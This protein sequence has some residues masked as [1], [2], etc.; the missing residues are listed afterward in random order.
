MKRTGAGEEFKRLAEIGRAITNSL[1]FSEVLELIV[2]NT[3][4]LVEADA[5][6]LLMADDD[7]LLR[8]R[9][10][11]GLDLED[12]QDFAAPFDE[13]VIDKLQSAICAEPASVIVSVPVFS[14]NSLNGLLV[15]KRNRELSEEGKRLLSAFADQASIA[16]RNAQLYEYETETA[17][18]QRI[19]SLAALRESEERFRQLA[20]NINDVFWIIGLPERNVLYVSPA[21][22]KRWGKSRAEL[23]QD[24]RAWQQMIHPDDQER[25]ERSFVE[26]AQVGKF[27]VEYR[28]ILP[29]KSVHWIRDR[30]Y[31]IKTDGGK[32]NRIA[33][34]AEDITARK[35]AEA[36][37]EQLLARERAARAEAER[38]NHLKDEFLATVSH[39]L[40]TPLTAILG[41]SDM[42]ANK[43]IDS[44]TTARALETILRNARAQQQI[45]DDILDVSR[46]ITGKLHLE[47]REI[48][49]RAS[50]EAAV[51]AVR[52][53][54][55]GKG[56]QLETDF[57]DS[58]ETVKCDPDR[59]QQVV[60]NLLTNA[61]KFTPAGGRIKISLTHEAAAFMKITVSD[62]GIGI[63]QNFLPYVF[64]RFRQA[65]GTSTRKHGGLGLGLSLVRHL[66]EMHGGTV[67]AESK[68]EGQGSTFTLLLPLVSAKVQSA[69]EKHS[70]KNDAADSLPKLLK[71]VKVLVVD[72]D[73]DSLEL[74]SF[75]L[76]EYGAQIRAVDSTAKALTAVTEFTPDVLLSDIAMPETNGYDLIRRVRDLSVK[77]SQG[78]DLYAI[79]LTA[80]TRED[81]R[82]LALEAGFQAH[83]SKPVELADLAQM[84]AQINTKK[85]IT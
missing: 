39:E 33:G 64:D 14:H 8:I 83:L 40:R 82:K 22:E 73:Q 81:D 12:I 84:I 71:G 25:I 21:Y 38:A 30:C 54:A 56:I 13:T 36:E 11:S 6:L 75:A 1:K 49:L 59:I 52:P 28:I 62:T 4:E 9:A 18:R 63:N 26:N 37:R 60:W 10:A 70:H 85:V 34:I 27:D 32:V 58:D 57:I 67:T 46:I 29:D 5:C 50:L 16:L 24:Y 15:V 68:G 72:D 51:D 69:D 3:G 17:R 31:P 42:L 79:A 48:N 23:Y 61:V 20:E 41:W 76:E 7:G 80:Y 74:I 47:M 55:S 77:D 65:H 2:V 35:A 45:I 66:V 78:R 53:A 44:A 19:E 43:N